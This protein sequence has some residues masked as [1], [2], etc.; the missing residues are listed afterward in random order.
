VQ[1]G[2][3][4]PF[5]PHYTPDYD[6]ALC[7]LCVYFHSVICTTED[8]LIYWFLELVFWCCEQNNIVCIAIIVDVG[9]TNC[10]SIKVIPSIVKIFIPDYKSFCGFFIVVC[11]VV[12]DPE[13]SNKWDVFHD[14]IRNNSANPK[15]W[16]NSCNASAFIVN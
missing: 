7:F 4:T 6:H 1:K 8:H 12:I 10:N 3:G 15:I 11:Y 5:P 16:K 13:L 2:V 9:A 14:R